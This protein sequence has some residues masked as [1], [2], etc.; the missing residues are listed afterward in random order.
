[1]TRIRE[2]TLAAI[3]VIASG[4]A[5]TPVYSQAAYEPK[6]GSVERAAMMNTLRPVVEEYLGPPVEFIVH[7]LKIYGDQAYASLMARRP[8]GK[9]IDMALTPDAR[10]YGHHPERHPGID[11]L[12]QRKG[13]TWTV[14]ALVISAT[15]IPFYGQPY[16]GT[17]SRVLPKD[18]CQSN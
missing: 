15:D 11:A 3:V 18:W 13:G 14:A 10:K 4:T 17:F 6:R 8:G 7:D 16:C 2:F 1:M 9:P 5:A 12:L